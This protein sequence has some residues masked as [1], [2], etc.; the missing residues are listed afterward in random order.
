MSNPN[1]TEKELRYLKRFITDNQGK[2]NQYY[3]LF[4]IVVLII[5][6]AFM[7]SVYPPTNLSIDV[8]D[9]EFQTSLTPAEWVPKAFEKFARL[10]DRTIRDQIL[11]ELFMFALMFSCGWIGYS[12]REGTR[13]RIIAKLLC[14]HWDKVE[15]GT[16]SPGNT[17][18]GGA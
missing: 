1:L 18:P 3:S 7:Y 9:I 17:T 10:T 11:D 4:V 6:G 13:N 5:L 2:W 15:S 12:W 8:K 16:H 14:A